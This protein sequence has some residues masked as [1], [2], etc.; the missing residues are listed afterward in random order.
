MRNNRISVSGAL[1][2]GLGLQVNQTLR[3]LI[4]S[5]NPI[6]SDGCVGLLKSVRNNK[7]SALELLDVSD[8]QVSR[9]CEDLASSMSEIL[10]G[11]CIKRYTSRRKDWPQAFTPSQ[12]A[13]APS[14]SGL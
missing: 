4:I 5:K 13:S 1:K 3:I 8:I 10:P 14:D 2:L 9:E 7:S 12:P 11:L 6:R